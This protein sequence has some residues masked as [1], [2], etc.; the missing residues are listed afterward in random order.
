MGIV[1]G[2]P[3]VA[4]GADGAAYVAV[5]DNWDS[6]W[7]ARVSGDTW[8]GWNYG[9]GI[10][11]ADPKA[12]ASG[13]GAIGIVVRDPWGVIWYRS[14]QEG[15]GANWT[16][17]QS[18]GG[19]LEDFAPAMVVGELNIAGRDAGNGLWWYRTSTGWSSAGSLSYTPGALSAG[20]R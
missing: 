14:F 13:S 16:N 7:V 11:S 8:T 4:C 15:T 10:M 2:K 6:L 17:W 18:T 3:L 9:G 12:A 20:P 1:K 5:R 19:L